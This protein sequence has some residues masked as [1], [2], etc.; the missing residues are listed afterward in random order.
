MVELGLEVSLHVLLPLFM[1]VSELAPG[2]DAT[3]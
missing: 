3:G 1:S 2:V